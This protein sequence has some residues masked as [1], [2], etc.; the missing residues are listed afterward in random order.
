MYAGLCVASVDLAHRPW[1]VAHTDLTAICV[2]VIWCPQLFVA[3]QRC[4]DAGMGCLPECVPHVGVS[5]TDDSFEV[6]QISTASIGAAGLAGVGMV[7]SNAAMMVDAGS[8]N[9]PHLW[10][11]G[12][13]GLVL[14]LSSVSLYFVKHKL[15]SR[16][17]SV[18][19]R[20]WNKY[21][22][23]EDVNDRV[24][25]ETELNTTYRHSEL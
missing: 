3:F 2:A 10:A 4:D 13:A 23:L 25:L 15:M 7:A 22:R 1:F 12:V 24:R 17:P 11:F 9:H 16:D 8:V 21:G 5:T 19:S 6:V 14:V 20:E 18:L